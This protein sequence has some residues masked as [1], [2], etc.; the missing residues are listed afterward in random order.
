MKKKSYFI[1]IL[2]VFS[3]LFLVSACTNKKA[4]APN[5]SP[6]ISSVENSLN[7]E[8]KI[9]SLCEIGKNPAEFDGKTVRLKVRIQFGIENTVITDE[10]CNL[11]QS[12]VTFK[13]SAPIGNIKNSHE[14][15]AFTEA[16]IEIEAKFINKPYTECC[17]TTPLQFKA[18]KIFELKPIIKK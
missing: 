5:N 8:N 9:S 15:G 16:D 10:N 1:Q 2:S 3:I 11:Y 17:T 14:K 18:A 12:V 7:V 4:T 13:E 6:A